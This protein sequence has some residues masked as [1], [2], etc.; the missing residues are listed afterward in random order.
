MTRLGTP[1]D[2]EVM[3][4]DV[5]AELIAA[6]EFVSGGEGRAEAAFALAESALDLPALA[7]GSPRKSPAHHPPVST[8]QRLPSGASASRRDDGAR[9]QFFPDQRVMMFGIVTSIG[10]QHLERLPGKRA[11]D[12]L[13][14]VPIVGTRPPRSNHVNE[15]MTARVAHPAD[16]GKMVLLTSGAPTVVDAGVAGLVAGRVDGRLSATRGQ[17][18]GR[19]GLLQ[20]ALQERYEALFFISRCSA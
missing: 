18:S 16:L 3:G 8:A 14:K 15:Q 20:S 7:V 11:P 10:Q 17:Q 1:N 4:E 2:G 12:R 9:P 5:E 6:G 19:A 13:W